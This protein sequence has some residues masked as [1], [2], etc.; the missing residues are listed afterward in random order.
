MPRSS[1]TPFHVVRGA[2]E[3]LDTVRRSRQREAGRRGPQGRRARR[4]YWRAPSSTAPA[5]CCYAATSDSQNEDAGAF[6]T[7]S[8]P[9]R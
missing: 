4:S 5:T 7:S 9:I 3:A 2:G 8:P 6:A 1:S